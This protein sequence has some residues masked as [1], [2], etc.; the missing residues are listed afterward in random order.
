MNWK[1]TI[2]PHGFIATKLTKKKCVVWHN[3]QWQSIIVNVAISNPAAFGGDR[4]SFP[5]FWNVATHRTALDILNVKHETAAISWKRYKTSLYVQWLYPVVSLEKRKAQMQQAL[6]SFW[7]VT[8]VFRNGFFNMM[9]YIY[10]FFV[11]SCWFVQFLHSP[12]GWTVTGS[13]YELIF[14][15]LSPECSGFI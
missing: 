15:N 2:W 4:N 1:T 6:M 10:I 12:T 5:I 11:I 8:D 3:V 13:K 9:L 7:S 14:L